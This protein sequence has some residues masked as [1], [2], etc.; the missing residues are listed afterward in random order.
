M[1]RHAAL[2]AFARRLTPAEV[3]KHWFRRGEEFGR[4]IRDAHPDFPA[5]G[6]DGLYLIDDVEAWFDRWHGKR[7]AH[8]PLH[9]AEEEALNIARGRRM[10]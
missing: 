4:E 3:A 8:A 5:P 2:T 10:A 9:E 6:P 7:H 1:K